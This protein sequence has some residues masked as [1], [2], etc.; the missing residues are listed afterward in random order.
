[1][2]LL[3]LGRPHTCHREGRPS[4]A[5][6]RIHICCFTRHLVFLDFCV[7]TSRPYNQLSCKSVDFLSDRSP[8]ARGYGTWPSLHVLSPSPLPGTRC[9]KHSNRQSMQTWRTP[10]HQ[11]RLRHSETPNVQRTPHCRATSKSQKAQ[12]SPRTLNLHDSA[13]RRT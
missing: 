11:V 3:A 5:N 1:M 9:L 4:A 8:W 2:S 6:S 7:N 13:K 12:Q 10:H